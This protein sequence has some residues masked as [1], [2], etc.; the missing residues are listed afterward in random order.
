MAKEQLEQ[1][2]V[3]AAEHLPDDKDLM[4]KILG[5]LASCVVQDGDVEGGLALYEEALAV[6]G[7]TDEAVRSKRSEEHTSELQSP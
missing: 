4:H 5:E 7:E 2:R 1:A 3:L 6:A